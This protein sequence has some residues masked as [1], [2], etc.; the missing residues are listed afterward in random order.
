MVRELLD[1][2]G[3]T[4]KIIISTG[5]IGTGKTLAEIMNT[6]R[7]AIISGADVGAIYTGLMLHGRAVLPL[8]AAG[9]EAERRERGN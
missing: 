9:M 1:N 4:D 8:V 6:G 3:A 7:E 5:G 2:G